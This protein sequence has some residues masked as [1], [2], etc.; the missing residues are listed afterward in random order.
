MS[1]VKEHRRLL[2]KRGFPLAAEH[3]PPEGQAALWFQDV[4]QAVPRSGLHVARQLAR[5]CG[6]DSQVTIPWRS[7]ADAVGRRNRAGNLRSYTE[8]GVR[9][10]VDAGWLTV[11]TTGSK[12]GAKTKF[13][14]QVGEFADWTGLEEEDFIEDEDSTYG[15]K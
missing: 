15:P 13:S 4:I 5:L 11:E 8:R 2:K 1:D 14:L 12:R 10:L 9:A 3:M 6:D 7:L